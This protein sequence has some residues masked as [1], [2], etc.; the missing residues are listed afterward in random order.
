[1]Q[2]QRGT[3]KRY[4]VAQLPIARRKIADIPYFQGITEIRDNLFKE[5]VPIS[6]DFTSNLTLNHVPKR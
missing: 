5:I 3:S 4:P 1:M 6:G 2:N